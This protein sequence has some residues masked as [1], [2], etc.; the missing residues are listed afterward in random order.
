MS[1]HPTVS[2]RPAYG[3]LLRGTTREQFVL[4]EGPRGTAKTRAILTIIMARALSTPGSRWLLA[5]STRTR[6]SQTVMQ[7]LEEQVFPSF[8]LCVPGTAGA[9]NRGRYDLPGG[10]VLL[11][12]GLDD[13]ARGQSLETAGIYVAEGV[14][15]TSAD[16]VL[17][18]AGS[19]RQA[20]SSSSPHTVLHQ[21]IVDGNPGPP[22]HWLNQIAEPIDGRLRRVRDRAD[23][24][25]L[26]Q[27]NAA[28]APDG[29]WK[30]IVTRHMDN[31]GYFD[32]RQWRW[33]DQGRAYMDTLRHL[34]GHLRRR[35]LD[36]DWVAAEGTVFPE[37]DDRRHVIRPFDV[38]IDWPHYV[39]V[40]PGYDHPCAI[41]W[42]A[43]APNG[44]IYVVD[45][46]YRGGMGVAQHA[47][48][49][50]ARNAGRTIKGYYADPQ[51]AF[52]RVMQQPKSIA[53]QFRECGLSFS[54]WPRST[55]KQ[56]MV[57]AVREMLRKDKL[58]VFAPCQHTIHEFQ[59]WSYKR[60]LS[61]PNNPPPGDDAYEDANNHSMDVV[62]GMVAKKIHVAKGR[63]EVFLGR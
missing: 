41:L 59:S 18:L 61:D 56:A 4:V 8:G 46:L 52:K 58:K 45:E 49:I 17:S 9:E 13:L 26:R 35:W 54:P 53:D 48:D 10:S 57:E 27:H 14:E 62:C 6:L 37:F 51:D 2:V 40:D 7:T 19:M 60:R 63:V 16:T 50:R 20:V 29:K 25:R 39:G 21:C 1:D 55:D 47:R 30:R 12:M 23:Y 5:R 11:P 3:G 43:V 28:P 15:I 22:G 36:G 31:P 34:R 42:F 24:D 33:T 44:T 32:L 38:P